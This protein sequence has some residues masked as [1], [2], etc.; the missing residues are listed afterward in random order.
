M[1]VPASAGNADWRLRAFSLL[2]TL[3]VLAFLVALSPPGALPAATRDEA[4]EHET[5]AITQPLPSPEIPFPE[6]ATTRSQA[7]DY[8]ALRVLLL[9][10]GPDDKYLTVGQIGR[11]ARVEVVG[12][13]PKG[14][15]V[16]VSLTPGSKLYG[17]VPVA[18]IAG[19]LDINALQVVP[20][21]TL[22]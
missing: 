14:D 11:G 3:G 19:L 13:N 18:A 1:E 20:V 17:W 15:W 7:P 6:N 8:R 4:A 10:L 2:L 9:Y 16:A 5:S 12:R 22:R 21:R